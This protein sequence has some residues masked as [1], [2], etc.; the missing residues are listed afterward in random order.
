MPFASNKDFLPA[1]KK[2]MRD[3]QW[4]HQCYAAYTCP[5]HQKRVCD[6]P[7]GRTGEASRQ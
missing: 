4:K 5:H 1:F 3:P 6:A 7:A 2:H